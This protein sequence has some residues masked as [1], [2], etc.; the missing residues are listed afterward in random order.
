[1]STY[2]KPVSGTWWL[3]R[4]PYLIFMIRELTS[5]FT[6][7]YCIFLLVLFFKLSQGPEAYSNIVSALQSPLSIVLH[8]ITF[9]F[10]LYHALTWFSLTPKILVFYK[11]EDPLPQSLVAAV[12]YG[13]WI[14]VSV[15]IGWLILTL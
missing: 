15:L 13:G 9:I 1:M 7:G 12:F 6:A 11:G 10:V 3:K 5:V 14:V 4:R 2:R 8:V